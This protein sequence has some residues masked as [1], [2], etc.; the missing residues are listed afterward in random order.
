VSSCCSFESY[1]L[2]PLLTALSNARAQD[3]VGQLPYAADA[4]FNS[5]AKQHEPVCLPDTR[6]DLLDEIYTWADGPDERCIFWLSGL[7]GT[8]KST[9]A[10]TVARK[11]YDGQGLAASFFFSRGGGDV[12]HAGKFVT[13]I[14]VQLAH[15]VPAV[16][17]HI[18]EAVAERGGIASHSLHDQW[19]HLVCRPLSKLH[20]PRPYVMVVD[21]LDECDNEYDVRIIVRLLA[22][23]RSS[24]TGV[25]LRVLLTSRPEVPIRFGF[26]QVPHAEHKNVVLHDVSPPSIDHDIGLFLED[27]L[28]TIQREHYL[29]AGWPGADK[30]MRLV[31]SASGLFIWAATAC[32]FIQDGRRFADERLE[33]IL[34]SNHNITAAPEKHLDQIYVTVLKGSVSADYTEEEREKHCDMLRY[35]LGSIVVLFSP[36]SAWCLSALL[37]LKEESVEQTLNDLHTIISIPEDRTQLLRLHHP[38]FRDFLLSKARCIDAHFWID[39][40]LVHRE[41]ADNCI[42]VMSSYL[43]R[44]ICKIGTP[45]ARAI[46]VGKAR[47]EQFLRPELRYA[48]L[49]WIPH[50]AKSGTQLRDGDPIHAFLQ[51]HYLH[52]LE[53]LGWMGNMPEG[54]HALSSL[55][56]LVL[57]S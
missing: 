23:V 57:V 32:R 49:Y 4:P 41:L 6:V 22:E 30:V 36:L 13:S 43:K 8:G 38:S 51:K 11:Y 20:D 47:V 7:A 48:C 14:A 34:C 37:H 21:A 16:R 2:A 35:V 50:F 56:S 46:E 25:Q 24:L 31:L 55:E 54:I 42:Q 40:Q 18:S 26:G 44:D 19:Q 9:I 10:R 45:S 1:H 52:W 27:K 39:E 17:Q 5:F 12:G 3:A 28:R 15:S 53:A 33:T 29:R